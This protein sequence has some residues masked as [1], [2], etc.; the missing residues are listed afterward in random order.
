MHGLTEPL[1]M[2]N[3]ICKQKH[4]KTLVIANILKIKSRSL[5]F[6]AV[7]TL[8]FP[9]NSRIATMYLTDF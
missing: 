6:L 5:D 3:V 9:N 2:K 4:V 7:V 1:L 8:K